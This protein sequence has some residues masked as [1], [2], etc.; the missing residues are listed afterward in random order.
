MNWSSADHHSDQRRICPLWVDAD[1]L[2]NRLAYGV[3][4]RMITSAGDPALDGVYKL[5]SINDGKTWH[6]AMK[7]SESP[8]KP[9]TRQEARLAS[10]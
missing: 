4:T 5:V 8:V 7:I 9:S 2:I 6:P 3:G 10:V 1:A